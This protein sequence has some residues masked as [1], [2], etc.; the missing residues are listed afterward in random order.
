MTDDDTVPTYADVRQTSQVAQE[1]A[2]QAAADEPRRVES[3]AKAAGKAAGETAARQVSRRSA[4]VGLLVALIVPLLVASIA[5][6]TAVSTA[7]DVADVQVALDRLAEAND[8]LASRGQPPVL[9][10]A[11]GDAEEVSAA[12]ITA[13]VLASLPEAPTAEQVADLLRG[14]VV[15]S[16]RGPSFDELARLSGDY[17]SRLPAPPGPSAEQIQTAVDRRYAENPPDPGRDGRN[18]VDG[19]NGQNGTDG[20]NGADGRNGID[21]V[22][23]QPGRSVL[24]GPEPVLVDGNCV[25]RTTYSAEP[26]VEEHPAGAAACPAPP[27]PPVVE[28]P[29]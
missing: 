28:L 23:G 11:G 27:T 13:Q 4:L 19:E 16:L 18:G 25:W 21:G 9:A 6:S 5:L 20:E 12:A 7:G 15:G 26:L 17:F 14:A 10:P 29:G 2:Q 22:D 1:L 3:I 24:T 8:E